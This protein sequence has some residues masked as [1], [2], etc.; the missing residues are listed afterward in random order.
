MICCIVGLLILTTVGRLRRLLGLGVSE[1]PAL[2]A[3][4]AQRPA[5][6][7]ALAAAAAVAEP[8]AQPPRDATVLGYGA[9]AV[10]FCLLAGPLLV[11][12]GAAE[13]TGS[14]SAWM[15]RNLCYL[16]VIVAAVALSRSMG[17][18]RVHRGPGP[19]M[20]VVGAVIFE[21]SLMDMHVFGVLKMDHA[22][23]M[24]GMVFHGVGPILVL[25]GGLALLNG[26]PYGSTGRS[27]TS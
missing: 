8:A 19:L 24:A 16:A 11:L 14:A 18:W 9:A 4:V 12:S 5:P 23:V 26:S 17:L 3:P 7:Q 6:G 21:L 15:L 2:F 10:A 13:N 1:T 27:T 22:N 25:T 20:I